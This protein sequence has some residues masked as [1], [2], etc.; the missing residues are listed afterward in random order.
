MVYMVDNYNYFS[1]HLLVFTEKCRVWG[2]LQ[3][4]TQ[5]IG[6]NE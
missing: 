3:G 2:R 6:I 5:S 1:L 4:M